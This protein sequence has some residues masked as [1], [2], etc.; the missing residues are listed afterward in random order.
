MESVVI[1]KVNKAVIKRTYLKVKQA[2]GDTGLQFYDN[3]VDGYLRSKTLLDLRPELETLGL[4]VLLRRKGIGIIFNLT[5][6]R[7]E[8]SDAEIKM[9][10]TAKIKEKNTRTIMTAKTEMWRTMMLT[11]AMMN[12]YLG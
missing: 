3:A 11:V 4:G 5:K 6:T 2:I 12:L 1:A 10:E 7:T 9:T 8:I